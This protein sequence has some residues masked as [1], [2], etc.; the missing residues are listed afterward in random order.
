[1][2]REA[3]WLLL[4]SLRDFVTS[5]IS[6]VCHSYLNILEF[7]IKYLTV[8]IS[9]LLTVEKPAE[10]NSTEGKKKKLQ[11]L[12]L[13]GKN[14]K[15]RERQK[16][17]EEN[18]DLNRSLKKTFI[19][20]LARKIQN[21][22]NDDINEH[23]KGL[24]LSTN[25]RN[26]DLFHKLNIGILVLLKYWG[27]PK[28]LSMRY[29][30]DE[31][32]KERKVKEDHDRKISAEKEIERKRKEEEALALAEISSELRE[33]N[34]GNKKRLR[35]GGKSTTALVSYSNT[36]RDIIA[37]KAKL[38]LDKIK[39]SLKEKEEIKMNDDKQQHL[40]IERQ[41]RAL[42]KKLEKR[43]IE[44]GVSHMNDQNTKQNTV[45]ADGEV[46]Y[47]KVFDS[48]TG[49]PPIDLIDLEDEEARDAEAIKIF[50]KKYSKLWRF[51]FKKYANIGF[52]A[53]PIRNFDMYQEKADTVNMAE[54]SKFLKDHGF[55]KQH[56]TK[57]EL[58]ALI[59]LI[60]LKKIKS[61]DLSALS[62]PGFLEFII[63]ASHFIYSRKPFFMDNL[64]LI[65]Q[66]EAFFE[67]M[68]KETKARGD[69]IT[70][71]EDPDSTVMA[72]PELLKAL[73]KK[74]IENP[75]Y[76]VP[77]GFKKVKEKTLIHNYELPKFIEMKESTQTALELL[78]ELVFGKFQFH[79]LEPI[80][81]SKVVTKIRPIIKR[82][83]TDKKRAVP[84]Y[85]DSLEGRVKPKGLKDKLQT[86]NSSRTTYHT[87]RKYNLSENMKL[88]VVN[89][90]TSKRP[91][92]QEC[93]ELLCDIL[94]AAEKGL[95]VLPPRNKYGPG[96]LKNK[97]ILMREHLMVQQ[98][99]YDTER[100]N[101][102]KKINRKWKSELKQKEEERKKH[103]E[104]TKAERLTHRKQAREYNKKRY[105][106]LVKHNEDRINEK[107]AKLEEI[108]SQLKKQEKE[109]REATKEQREQWKE[110]H[111]K[112]MAK[113][114]EAYQ[115]EVDALANERKELKHVQAELEV[116]EK[117]AKD[118]VK[119]Q[120]MKYFK[121]NKDKLFFDKKEKEEI[122]KFIDK[123]H[124]KELFQK[125]DTPLR[126][127]FEFYS[128]SEHH[129]ISFQ[130]D[131]NME[132]MN[133]KE[134]I[135]FGYQSHIVPALL[136]V[137]EMSHTYRL[138][139]RERQDE[140]KDEKM[141]VL[142][143]QYFIKALVRVAAISQDYLGGQRGKKLEK[144][145]EELEKEKNRTQKLKMSLA[146][147]FGKKGNQ[148]DNNSDNSLDRGGETSGN[149]TA[150][151][152]DRSRGEI[153]KRGAKKPRKK[154]IRDGFKDTTLKNA[155][156]LKNVVSEAEILKRKSKNVNKM[157]EK[158]AKAE[159]LDHIKNI[160]M[161]NTR[162]TKQVD[163]DIITPS[164][165]EALI[166][167]LQILP[168]DD[169]YSLD[170]KLNKVIRRNAGAKPN[171]IVKTI[172]PDKADV[173]DKDTSDEDE[174]PS[175]PKGSDTNKSKTAKSESENGDG[176][177]KTSKA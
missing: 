98:M 75:D 153:Y 114:Q 8:S 146:K 40:K 139:V 96:G 136:P 94:D 78:D 167:Y 145:V 117:E 38:E 2:Q 45:F 177:D 88:E 9:M 18:E 143:Y 24:C 55:S 103:L 147:K 87:Q 105:E 29:I 48:H 123:P 137:E 41:K 66:I 10:D 135:R 81:H 162:V 15:A 1:M 124:V 111:E 125:Y 52:S 86:P 95:T 14:A 168:E 160:K 163:V 60:N 50:M 112:F 161:E 33:T 32:D 63:Q 34:T 20:E 42:K 130:L 133:Y 53:K 25:R 7:I 6:K 84:R 91:Q 82:E 100:Y 159:I 31:E 3:V 79:I 68:E 67:Q 150:R 73:N 116:K 152:T 49:I 35:K 131:H 46:E 110:D 70:L 69:S 65:N 104:D 59:R 169:K 138:L 122:N 157:L 80:I 54:L 166:S 149:E 17:K 129:K 121:E 30:Q 72:D 13:R 61:F 76:P 132:T 90:P 171:R 19:V 97:G 11:E 134:F 92:M 127:F 102:V 64:P 83:F 12:S 58:T 109:Y 172:R 115:K 39:L 106:K 5:I 51:M 56:L 158:G 62:Y 28:S 118:K 99:Q 120:V 140:N 141:Q 43:M 37:K 85:L 21:L 113:Q 26:K 107:K 155:P 156:L 47:N 27:D 57:E 126:Y 119:G 174:Q 165:I 108:S 151:E 101:S 144:R 36:P 93:A 176:D 89:Q 154:I 23:L 22:R 44:H 128:R 74:L 164:T 16:K 170:K 173:V 142:D 77:E 148:T 4:P 175:S 71:F